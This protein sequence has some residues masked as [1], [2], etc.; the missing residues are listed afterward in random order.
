M[1]MSRVFLVMWVLTA[2]LMLGSLPWLPEQVG[3]AGKVMARADYLVTLV[4]PLAASL[5]CSKAFVSW[6][7]EFA[8]SQL[9]LPHR[10][11][12]MAPPRRQATL[13]RAGEHVA[14]I[15]VM[16]L[17]MAAGSHGAVL[18]DANPQ[19]PQPPQAV[20]WLLGALWL[21][22]LLGQCWR[23]HRAFPAPPTHVEAPLRRPRRP[24]ESH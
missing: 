1:R 24:G 4:L 16:V 3:E 22:G 9:K 10:D 12:W 8:P 5:M 20:A 11:Y 19:W 14:G 6:L 2:G 17:L 15:G 13:D 21:V 18:L 7:G 23:L